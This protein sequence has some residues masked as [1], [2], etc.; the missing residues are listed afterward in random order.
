[1]ELT[2][3]AFGGGC[4]WCTEAVFQ[5]LIGVHKVEQGFISSTDENNT[6]SEAVIVHFE[7]KKI[8]LKILI[9]IHLRTHKS[10]S[11]HS[12]R[13]K[14]R[15]AVYYYSISQK[16]ESLKIIDE[17]KSS[18][19]D[20]I[21]T[22]VVSFTSFKPSAVAFQ[23]YYQSNPNKPFCETYINPK[24]KF[25]AQNFATQI[26]KSKVSHFISTIEETH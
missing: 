4:H 5:A 11:N 13:N 8:E 2:K 26:E 24:L 20:K 21:I 19:K 12:M 25:L 18:F 22:K 23:N 6:F 10:T 7:A 3:I 17:L 15:S 14:Y 16:E 1:M 9:E